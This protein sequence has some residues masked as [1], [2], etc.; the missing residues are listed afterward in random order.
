MFDL[1]IFLP[2][3][4][5][6]PLFIINVNFGV[7]CLRRNKPKTLLWGPGNMEMK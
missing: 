7:K 1:F 4:Y 5:N 6:D 3:Y 2:V